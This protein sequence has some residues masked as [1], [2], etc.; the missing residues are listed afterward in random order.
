M[1]YYRMSVPDLL[2][3]AGRVAQNA[4]DADLRERLGP[5]GYGE[6]GLGELGAL[7]AALKAKKQARE[8]CHGRQLGATAS[9]DAAWADFYEK[10]YMV[11]VGIAR[12][13][14]RSERG[15]RVRLGLVGDRRRDK[16]GR[17]DQALLL[18]TNALADPD[19]LG[20]L[21]VRG[22]GEAV[23]RAGAERVEAIEK[24]DHEQDDRI[25]RAKESTDA[26]RE[27]ERAV[28]KWLSAFRDIVRPALRDKPEWLERLG[29]LH[30]S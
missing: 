26:R 16:A 2:H 6:E 24:A 23:L 12:A 20:R 15:T 9:V 4:R 7:I 19:L 22:M 30:R 29:I 11:H 10:T 17:Y 1:S 3:T 27:A 21:A 5:I 13:V 28:A 14:F 18:Y 25:G 8:M